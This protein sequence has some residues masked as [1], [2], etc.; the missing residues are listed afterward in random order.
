MWKEKVNSLGRVPVWLHHS[1]SLGHGPS[2]WAE[3]R[4]CVHGYDLTEM[5]LLARLD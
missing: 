2:A 1:C 3:Y 5:A 4:F